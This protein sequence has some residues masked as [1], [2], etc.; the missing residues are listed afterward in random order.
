MKGHPRISPIY[1]LGP[2]DASDPDRAF[3]RIWK[4][5]RD[6]WVLNGTIV[7][8][9]NELPD[10]LRQPLVDWANDNYGKQKNGAQKIR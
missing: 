9:P 3:A 7:A 8:K 2:G 1:S 4:K 6:L 5:C 10:H